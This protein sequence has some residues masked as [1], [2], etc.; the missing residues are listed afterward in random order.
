MSQFGE[1]LRELEEALTQNG[2]CLPNFSLFYIS[3]Q[4]FKNLLNNFFRLKEKDL[5]G[6]MTNR[7]ACSFL[8]N[9]NSLILFYVA[10]FCLLY[11]TYLV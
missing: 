2:Q 9:T 11:S 10:F 8:N 6:D 1:E 3:N 7:K 5:R 4:I